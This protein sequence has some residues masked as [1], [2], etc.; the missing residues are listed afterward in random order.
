MFMA[1]LSNVFT[2]NVVPL[3]SEPNGASEQVS[4]GLLGDTVQALE[5]RE[6][7]VNV[8]TADEYTGWVRTVHLRAVASGDTLQQTRESYPHARSAV[9]GQAFTDV[10]EEATDRIGTK[11]VW[12]TRVT[13]LA[14]IPQRTGNYALARLPC[15]EYNASLSA[16]FKLGRVLT[17][18][19]EPPALAADFQGEAAC[20]LAHRFIGTPY[21]WGG[22]TPFGFD[23]SGFVQRIYAVLGVTLP[24]DAYLQAQSSLGKFHEPG[25]LRKAGDL[26]FFVGPNDSCGRGITHVGLAL[27]NREF[28]HA[29]GKTGV[30]LSAFEDSEIQSAYTYRGAWRLARSRAKTNGSV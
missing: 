4:Q 28:I 15:G 1:T 21:L 6:D 11:L 7:F 19:L 27:N 26:V 9:V 25:K 16:P 17:A 30:T 23:C 5:Q 22:G 10:W 3:F 8:R 14:S 13:L 29:Y 2:H 12:G 24:R 20:E 18:A